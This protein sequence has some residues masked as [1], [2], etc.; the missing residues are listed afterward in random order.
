MSKLQKATHEGKLTIGELEIPCAVLA[1]GTR[2]ISYS[3]VFKAF[4]R[5]IR[6]AHKEGKF[7][8][9]NMPAFLSS[10]NLQPFVGEDLRGVLNKIDYIDK[11]NKETQ[12]F[13]ANILPMLCKVYLDARAGGILVKSQLPLAR[14][15]EILLLGLSKIGIIAL[16]D[17]ATGYQYEREK[18]ELQTILKAYIAAELLP[19]QKMFPDEFYREI[20]RLNGWDYTV[21]GIKQRPS[22]IGTWTKKLIYQQLPKGVLQELYDKTPKTSTGKLAAKLHQSLTTDI[23]NPHL[24]KQLVSVITLMNISKNWKE[25]LRFFNKK[26]GQQ[27][28]EFEEV[29]EVKAIPRTTFDNALINLLKT[30]PPKKNK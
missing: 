14:A 17:E 1:D 19:W 18:D 22:V 4:G 7:R 28:I 21:N 16:V 15:S 24:E 26:F 12:G 6:G 3:A 23:G 8:A 13:D 20:F 29:E 2:V 30:K 27:E 10:N 5:T 25:F 9:A 11:N